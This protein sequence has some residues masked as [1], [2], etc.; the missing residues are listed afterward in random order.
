MRAHPSDFRRR[1]AAGEPLL[2]TFIKTPGMHGVEII[3]DLGYDFVVIDEE[4]APFDRAAIDLALLAARAAGVAGLV[5]VASANASN[6]LSALDCGAQ[7]VL[8]P[9]VVGASVARDIVSACRYR[10]GRRGFS[11]SP[12]AGRYG[13]VAPAAHI[14][15]QDTQ[16]AVIAMIED[17]AALDDIDAIVGVDGVD[18][19]FIGRGDLAA[20]FGTDSAEAP[21]VASAVERVLLSALGR[22]K[23]VCLMVSGAADARRFR[24]MGATV[25]IV[26]TDQG[27]LR[28]AAAEALDEMRALAAQAVSDVGS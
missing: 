18:A 25:F 27:F 12:R 26:S 11:N 3:G 24:A 23:P 9:H 22:C 13:A 19:V 15:S 14:E 7:G 28:R 8:V 2:G 1:L 4:H 17:P 21:E 6:L 16:T 20:A 10:G 5:R